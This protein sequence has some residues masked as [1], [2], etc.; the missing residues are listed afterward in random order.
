MLHAQGLGYRDLHVIDIAAVPYGLENT[1]GESK[2]EYILNC[3]FAEIMIDSVDLVLAQDLEKLPVEIL[4]GLQIVAKG[5][6]DHDPPPLSRL[7]TRE[8][9]AAEMVDDY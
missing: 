4:R 9:G 5:L 2:N 3:F 8:T 7:L 6:L 1:I